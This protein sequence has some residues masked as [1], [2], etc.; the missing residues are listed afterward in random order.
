MDLE[1]R[2]PKRRP[3]ASISMSAEKARRSTFG[4]SEQM[5]LDSANGSMGTT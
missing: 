2:A 5:P 3:L 1:K 4:L